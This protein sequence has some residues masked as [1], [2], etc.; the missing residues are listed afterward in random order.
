MNVLL[1]LVLVACTI[2]GF[3]AGE[4]TVLKSVQTIYDR[5]P[6]LR[7][8]GTGFDADEHDITLELAATGQASLRVDKDFLIS[9]DPD[10]EGIILKLLSA[11]RCVDYFCV[12]IGE[13]NCTAHK[14]FINLSAHKNLTPP[15]PPF[16]L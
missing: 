15:H 11:R 6:K 16:P 14:T 5:S 12:L 2:C 9:K 3:V 8:K 10:G 7:I 13:E 4:V 1:L